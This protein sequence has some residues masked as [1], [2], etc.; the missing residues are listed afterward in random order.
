MIGQPRTRLRLRKRKEPVAVFLPVAS[1]PTPPLAQTW[2]REAGALATCQDYPPSILEP[3]HVKAFIP[4]VLPA[5]HLDRQIQLVS[6]INGSAGPAVFIDL[7]FLGFCSAGRSKPCVSLILIPVP[8]ATPRNTRQNVFVN[9][10]IAW[11]CWAL[12][13]PS[14][15]DS[16]SQSDS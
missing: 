8:I 7:S 2:I 12:L 14:L 5:T 16:K 4:L 1:K 9:L 10:S 3:I 13:R 11:G 6:T 15:S